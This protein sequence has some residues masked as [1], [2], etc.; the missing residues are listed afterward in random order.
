MNTDDP[1]AT[2]GRRDATPSSANVSIDPQPDQIGR[3]RI[4]KELGRGG[5]GLV[6]LAHDEQLHR[7]VAIKVPHASLIDRPEDAQAYLAEAR[8]VAGLDHAN[9]VPVYDVGQT[10]EHPCYVVSKYVQ[11]VDLATKLKRNRLPFHE[12]AELVATVADA[13]HYAHTKGLVHRDIK[14]GNILIDGDTRPHVVDFG[15][16]LS[17]EN[18]GKGPKLAGTPA[19]MSPE[20]ARGEGHRV[21]GRSDVFSLGVVLYELLSQRRPFRG[22]TRAELLQQVTRHDA[23]PLRQVDDRI[24]KELVRICD[25]AMAKRASDR[26]STAKDFGEDLRCYLADQTLGPSVSTDSDFEAPPGSQAATV[27]TSLGSERVSSSST[28]SNV[29]SSPPIRVVPKG[30][31]SFDVHDADFF[32]ELLPGPRDRNN[33]PET[34]RFWK[35]RIEET[36]P[37]QTFPVGLIY[38][39]S[40]CGKSSLVKAGLLPQLS[41]D[42]IPIYVEATPGETET[43]LLNRLRRS[44]PALD[45]DRNLPTTLAALRTGRGVSVGKK[46]LIVLDQFEQW[47]YAKKDEPNAELVQALR[48]CDGAT[49]QCILMVRDD[50]WLAVSRFLRALEVRLSEGHNVAL[51]DVFDLDHARKVL[52][53]FGRA[54]GRLPESISD[55]SKEQKQFLKRSVEG[56]AE[57]GHVICVRLALFAEM[58]KGK[59][60]TVTTLNQVGGARGI[61][62]TFLEETFSATTAS[63]EHRYHQKAARAVLSDLLPASGADIKGYMRSRDELLEVSGYQD[64]PAEFDELLQVL[65]RELRLITPTDPAG[66]DVDGEAS[67]RISEDNEYFQLTHDYLVPALR[68]WLTRKQKE[69]RKGRAELKLS[70]TST[71]WNQ[72]PENR[73]LPTWWDYGRIRLLTDR[74]RWTESQRRMMAKATRVHGVRSA[75]ALAALILVTSMGLFARKRII[76]QQRITRVE[77]FVGSLIRAQPSQISN[78]IDELNAYPEVA[79]DL[80][81]PLVAGDAKTD[82]AKRARLHARLAMV[83]R[84][85]A[86]ID[87]LI[88]ELLSGA[89][90]YAAP[91]REQL[92]PVA[93]SRTQRFGSILHDD[94]ADKE[95]RFRAALALADFVPSANAAFWT[96]ADRRLVVKELVS[97]NPESQPPLR[98]LLSPIGELLLD[99]L[100]RVFSDSEASDGQRLGAANAIAEYARDDIDKLGELL[101]IATPEQFSVLYPK[102]ASDPAPST[103]A[104]FRRIASTLPP[105]GLGSVERVPFGQRRAN[106]AVTLL[107]LKQPDDAMGVFSMDD[108]PEAMTQFLFRCRPRGVKVPSLLDC[109]SIVGAAASG[110]SPEPFLHPLLLALGEFELD[111]IPSAA[112]DPLIQRLAGWYREHPRSSVHGAAGWLL[113]R[114]G[115]H[116]IAREVDQTVR[117]FSP[118]RDW[119]TQAVTVRPSGVDGESPLTKTFYFTFVIFPHGEYQIGSPGD[120]PDRDKDEDQH[121]IELTR[122]F[123]ILDREIT[124]EE[125]IAFSPDY[126]DYAAQYDATL[127]NAG[128]GANWYD[129]VRCCRWMGQQAGLSEAEQAYADPDSL[130]VEDYPR[131]VDP[132][133]AWAPRNWPLRLDRPGFRLPTESEWEVACRSGTRTRFG[134]GGQ[135]DLLGHFG[136]FSENSQRRIHS[137]R[138]LRPN[139]RGLFDMHGNL[140]EWHHDWYDEDPSQRV[141]DPVGP[142]TGSARGYRGSSWAAGDTSCRTANRNSNTP[143]FRASYRGF[144][145]ALTLPSDEVTSTH[146]P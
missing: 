146:R 18:L 126:A 66:K 62:V 61:G 93:S 32:L 89:I 115:E 87:P 12:A 136:W 96:A 78:V 142:L 145:L 10:A 23:R 144:R 101:T 20:Q 59:P 19:Y 46:V 112:R 113:R 129:A 88:E 34:L 5:F 69:T 39:P 80:L 49:V 98:S 72:K 116:S 53:A 24:P 132:S 68:L 97:T 65:D 38:G 84:D 54:H 137:P 99:D 117:P 16:A 45:V 11:G 81:M 33:L 114:W 43:R 100:E 109:L 22:D 13:L 107:R 124:F 118:D 130:S 51:A 42:V 120:E 133:A 29:S 60:W 121:R 58:M 79:D 57:E 140:Y 15:L 110:R 77:G 31:R 94:A 48:Q 14:P 6:Y 56:L 55:V 40:G 35:V 70:D 82:D 143:T 95:R 103:I 64:R 125:L 141:L 44:C 26:F 36:D 83:S 17:E 1:F 108:D 3:Y 52:A 91:I 27:E 9:I 73:F 128:A 106:A 47:L 139:L 37:D 104:K 127:A 7:Q 67:S 41:P 21:D 111:E 122:S 74:R 131:E 138:E 123:A 135:L 75:F 25:K 63:P 86:L 92:K 50:F 85:E 8:T 71:T 105:P 102:V 119:F 134:F 28:E 90:A 2:Q 4:E 30:L 76:D